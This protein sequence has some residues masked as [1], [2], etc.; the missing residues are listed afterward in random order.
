M[1]GS[2]SLQ[3]RHSYVRKENLVERTLEMAKVQRIVGR[4]AQ[5]TGLRAQSTEQ[6]AQSAGLRAND[7]QLPT[8]CQVICDEP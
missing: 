3:N 4:R 2:K 1:D 7:C 5:S 8:A 6:R